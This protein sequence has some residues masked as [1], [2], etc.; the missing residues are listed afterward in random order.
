MILIF[1]WLISLTMAISKPIHVPANSIISFFIVAG[2]SSI[3]CIYHMFFNH[4]SVS[5]HFGFF[6]VLDV[7]NSA[8]VNVEG[9]LLSQISI[10]CGYTPRVELTDHAVAIFLVIKEHLYCSPW[11][12]YQLTFP[13]TLQESSLSSTASLG[14]ILCNLFDDGHSGVGWY[15]LVVLICISLKSSDLRHCIMSFFS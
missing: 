2:W 15:L 9:Q 4:S 8:T 14:F 11:W 6:H 10:F 3:I 1:V 13:P 12:L 7:A 5:A